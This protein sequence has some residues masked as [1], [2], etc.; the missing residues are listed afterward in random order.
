[1]VSKSLTNVAPSGS[2]NEMELPLHSSFRMPRKMVCV[3]RV[4]IMAGTFRSK[5]I[6]PFRKPHRVQTTKL[7]RMAM[8][9]MDVPLP[10]MIMAMV[11]QPRPAMAPPEISIPLVMMMKVC[12]TARTPTMAPCFVRF[13]RL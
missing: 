7:A 4:A 1:M 2:K 11:M 12:A 10:F 3:P 8:P 13:F 9:S 5:M 6:T